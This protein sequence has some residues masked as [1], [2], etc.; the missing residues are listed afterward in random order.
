MISKD[1]RTV[2]YVSI[3]YVRKTHTHMYVY[4]YIHT[5]INRHIVCDTMIREN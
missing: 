4:V 2:L 1:I 5:Y 3:V